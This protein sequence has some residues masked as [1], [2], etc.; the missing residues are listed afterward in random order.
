MLN[1]QLQ[2]GD[3]QS[4]LVP[5]QNSHVSPGGQPSIP[6]FPGVLV[7]FSQRGLRL[8]FVLA[9]SILCLCSFCL[10]ALADCASAHLVCPP[11]TISGGSVTA[12]SI[13]IYWSAA[14]PPTQ[15][16]YSFYQVGWLGG[17]APRGQSP[18]ILAPT[19]V[20]T[21][22]PLPPGTHSV[23]VQGCYGQVF[24]LA[25]CSGWTTKSIATS[26][27]PPCAQGTQWYYISAQCLP[28]GSYEQICF[29]MS[30]NEANQMLTASCWYQPD[31]VGTLKFKQTILG[32]WD[33]APGS[34]IEGIRG[35]LQC[36]A[37]PTTY[38][39]GAAVPNGSYQQSCMWWN[40]QASNLA[41]MCWDFHDKIDYGNDPQNP[42]RGWNIVNLDLS[43]CDMTK[44]IE[45]NH[46]KLA[47][48][49][50]PLGQ[51]PLKLEPPG[52]KNP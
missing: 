32:V 49:Q 41:A 16:S 45:N 26:T 11:P 21:T 40:V 44:D 9:V 25:D 42:P 23:Q 19:T 18:Q 31:D 3:H 36:R 43:Q 5:Q 51:A 6:L 17:G 52:P 29:N 38:G 50:R 4:D 48:T 33:C 39:Y 24:S 37:N 12:N 46:G 10:P 2:S 14:P 35:R 15:G 30:Y 1:I 34:D 7:D 27:P 13:T 28:P 8:T 20:Y 47:C 22:P